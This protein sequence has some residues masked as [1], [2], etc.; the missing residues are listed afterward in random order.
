MEGMKEKVESSMMDAVMYLPGKG[1]LF[2]QFVGGAIYRYLEIGRD[3]YDTLMGAESKGEYFNGAIKGKYPTHRVDKFPQEP[4][5]KPHSTTGADG[6]IYDNYSIR[7]EGVGYNI[8]ICRD[9][10]E[11]SV[12]KKEDVE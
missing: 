4:R 3:V 8:A 6:M 9:T 12:S 11:M 2:I 10:K 5:I 7:L 1:E